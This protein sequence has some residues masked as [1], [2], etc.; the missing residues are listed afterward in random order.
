MS[1]RGFVAGGIPE[2]VVAFLKTKPNGATMKEIADAIEA[3]RDAPRHSI[4]SAVFQN[5]DGK[6]R[7]LFE[8]DRSGGVTKA[9]YRLAK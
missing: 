8:V 5:A 7:A 9:I 4:R 1:P 3:R 6:G 2:A